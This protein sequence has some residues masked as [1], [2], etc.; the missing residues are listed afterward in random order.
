MKKKRKIRGAQCLFTLVELLVVIA[1]IAILAGMLLPALNSAREKAREIKC[2]ANMKQ[3][4]LG[5]N[6]Y[7]GDHN[8][9]FPKV[10]TS[11]SPVLSWVTQT[12]EYI[13]S[14]PVP[15]QNYPKTVFM[16]P[17][18][19]HKC[20][21][22]SGLPLVG[23][24]YVLYGYNYQLGGLANPQDWGGAAAIPAMTTKA[25]PNPS[26]HLLVMDITGY[27]CTDGHLTAWI[28]NWINTT[29]PFARHLKKMTTVMC[30]AGNLRTFPTQYVRGPNWATANYTSNQP[31]NIKLLKTAPTP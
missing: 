13:Y 16:C 24:Q 27:N 15:S 8:D 23:P 26:A 30:V 6:L 20:V 22:T 17:C 21:N 14:K 25:I 3:I 29:T 12:A 28:G 31:W 7:F 4:G 9:Q 18:D 2:A 19:Q 1:I 10:S 5:F 11:S